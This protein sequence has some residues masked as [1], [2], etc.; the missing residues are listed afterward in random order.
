M[1]EKKGMPL[2]NKKGEIVKCECGGIYRWDGSLL[3]SYPAK[4]TFYCED[5]GDRITESEASL[6]PERFPEFNN[7]TL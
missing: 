4:Y 2:T 7:K 5:C 6:F 3:L 1:K